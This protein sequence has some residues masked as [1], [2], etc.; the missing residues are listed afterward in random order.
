MLR[1]PDPSSPSMLQ[2]GSFDPRVFP[3]HRDVPMTFALINETPS[4]GISHS[5]AILAFCKHSD[6]ALIFGL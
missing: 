4:K 1:S 6:K 3:P 2:S 5:E